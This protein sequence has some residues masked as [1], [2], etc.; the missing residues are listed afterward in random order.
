MLDADE[1]SELPKVSKYAGLD[2]QYFDG[3]KHLGLVLAERAGLTEALWD[4]FLMYPP[5]A[6]WTDEGPPLPEVAL[7]QAGGVVVASP[8]LLPAIADQS[9]LVPALR[10]QF[11][12]VAASQAEF[13]A[14]LERVTT[15]FAARHLPR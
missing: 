4:V 14:L 9:K 15:E 13:P 3:E 1:G 10:G 2:P 6:A 12:V 7:A 11:V 8:G 5:G